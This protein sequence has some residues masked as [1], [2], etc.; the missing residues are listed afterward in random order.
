MPVEVRGL[1]EAKKALKAFEPDLAVNLNKEVRAFAAPVVKEAK[2]FVDATAGGLT[3][4]QTKT[5]PKKG[6][7]ARKGFPKFNA[8]MV[9][10]GIKFSSAPTRKNSSGFISLYRIINASA[11]GAI[12]ETAGTKNLNSGKSARPNFSKQLGS[13]YGREKL[14]GR[15]I[16]RAWDEDKGK[17]Q[18]RI[19][20]A[21][22]TTL[23]QLQVTMSHAT[24]V[25]NEYN[26]QSSH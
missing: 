17:A 9:K 11:A 5:M 16:Y 20:S 25:K 10:R 21:V 1:K 24:V 4:W 26:K 8:S 23:R 18:G 22:D 2:A 7:T 13:T 6:E 15:L 12:Y 14:R 3:N 19:V